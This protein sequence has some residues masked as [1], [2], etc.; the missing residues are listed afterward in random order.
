MPLLF[1]IVVIVVVVAVEVFVVYRGE[2]GLRFGRY[3]DSAQLKLVPIVPYPYRYTN[4]HT[5]SHAHLPVR[6]NHSPLIRTSR[7]FRLGAL[8][9]DTADEVWTPSTEAISC[10][11]GSMVAADNVDN[12]ALVVRGIW[13]ASAPDHMVAAVVTTTAAMVVIGERL[14]IVPTMIVSGFV[15]FFCFLPSVGRR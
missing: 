1:I 8:G 13:N 11:T 6:S 9:V 7:V 15:P 4:T 3:L 5:R 12:D 10:V 2:S 14:F